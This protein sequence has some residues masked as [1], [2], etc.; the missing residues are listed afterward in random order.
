MALYREVKRNYLS[1]QNGKVEATINGVKEQF[2][3]VEGNLHSI[4]RVERTF[5]GK[6]AQRWYVEMTDKGG[7][8]Y[9]LSFSL[10]SGTFRNLILYLA[11]AANLTAD[12]TIRIRPYLKGQYTNVAVTA[13]GEKLAWAVTK[14]P[15]VETINVGG[16]EVKDDSKRIALISILVEQVNGRLQKQ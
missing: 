16:K 15:P 7:E 14:I 2:D 10:G 6:T 8:N 4:T 13:D 5:S 1:L 12:T 9:T 11:S 3:E